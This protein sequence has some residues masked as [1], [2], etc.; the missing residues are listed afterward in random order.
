MR[1]IESTATNIWT[2]SVGCSRGI[3]WVNEEG[4]N[5]HWMD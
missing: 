1:K 3:A 2:T 4:L 5:I